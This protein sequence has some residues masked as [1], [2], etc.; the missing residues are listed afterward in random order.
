MK[1]AFATQDLHTLDAHFGGARN[2]AIY[3]VSPEGHRF[4][5]AVRFDEVSNQDGVHADEGHDRLSARVE[6]LQGCALLFV[7]AIG[8][9]AAARV[10]GN[11][12]H[13]V[14]LPRPEPIGDILERIR[15]MLNGTPPPWLRKALKSATPDQDF[16]DE[17][18]K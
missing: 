4:L 1:V 14:K 18:D 16:L 11:K 10:V 5:E 7:L 2:L 13:P 17:D 15:I 3:D 9:P 12:I 8:G 6:A